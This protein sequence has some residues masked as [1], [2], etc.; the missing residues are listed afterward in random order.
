MGFAASSWGP[1]GVPSLC[2][3]LLSSPMQ[4]VLGLFVAWH[5]SVCIRKQSGS[6]GGMALD[7]LRSCHHLKAFKAPAIGSTKTLEGV[8]SCNLIDCQRGKNIPLSFLPFPLSDDTWGGESC[9]PSI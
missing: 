1:A 4:Q 2:R 7:Q 9:A 3:R 8:Y 6:A 5:R